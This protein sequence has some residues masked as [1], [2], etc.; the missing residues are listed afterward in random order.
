MPAGDPEARRRQQSPRMPRAPEH[1]ELERAALLG[2]ACDHEG[3]RVPAPLVADRVPQVAGVDGVPDARGVDVDGARPGLDGPQPEVRVLT[4]AVEALVEAPDALEQ[5]ARVGDVAR[6]VPRARTD[7]RLAAGE[8]VQAP[9]LVGIRLGPAL[10]DAIAALG[11]RGLHEPLEPVRRRPAVV[12]GEGDEPGP[13]RRD[14]LV[15]QLA[16][17]SEARVDHGGAQ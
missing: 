1:P 14:P 7:D 9:E 15:A 6:L 5:L 16:R 10:Q 13:R 17:A 8:A 3:D 12:V 4:T 11:L 2:M